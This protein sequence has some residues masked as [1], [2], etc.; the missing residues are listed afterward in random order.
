[1]ATRSHTMIWEFDS[2]PSE[3]WP[4]LADTARFNEAAGLPKHTIRQVEQSDGSVRFFADA[5]IGPIAVEWEEIPVEWVDNRWFSHERRFLKG[6]LANIT[7]TAELAPTSQGCRCVYNLY[8][9]PASLFGR[10][11][12]ATTFFSSTEKTFSRL[13]D[14]IRRFASGRADRAFSATRLE[15]D[16]TQSNRLE[17]IVA[18]IEDSPNDHGLARRLAEFVL[19]GQEVDLAQIRPKALARLWGADELAVTELCLQAVRDGL[20]ESRWDILCPRCRGAQLSSYALDQLPTEAHCLSCNI[21][22]DR[23]FARNVELSFHPAP[24]IRPVPDGEFCLFGPMST[25]HVK[26][27]V[28]VDPGESR[29]LPADFVPGPYRYRTLETGEQCD[30][31][32]GAVAP[33]VQVDGRTV[34]AGSPSTPGSILLENKGPARR[35][36]VVE[37][38]AWVE[39]ALTAHTATTLQAFRDLFSG[40]VLHPGDQVSIAQIAL[41]FT[42][43][44]GSTALYERIGDAAAYHLVREHFAFL[45]AIIRR[46]R[47]GIVKTIGDAVMA[48]FAEPAD[49][50]R[51]ALDAQTMIA[52][53]NR[54]QGSAGTSEEDDAVILKIGA[55]AGHCIAVTLND[56]L[57]YFG[58]MVNLAARVQGLADGGE[59]VLTSSLARDP[60][61]APLLPLVD[62]EQAPVR[63]FDSPVDVVRIA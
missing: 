23:D 54:E 11:M 45:G 19:D 34:T 4:L 30:I 58:S 6:P 52:A 24:T 25:P 56:R 59:V 38:R 3:I 53:F 17:R 29:T 16:E 22:Y 26:L 63:G 12:L 32:I 50:V 5:K 51:A 61:V 33:A 13:A 18:A 40:E 27:Q 9:E 36:V 49:A 42:D 21:S 35:T 46:N 15:L 60:S 41:M 62:D 48:A 31:Q 7:A 39:D 43:L 55:H 47:G 57:D 44:K 10:L 2:P 20:L 14:D 37:S 28:A 1:M 8:A